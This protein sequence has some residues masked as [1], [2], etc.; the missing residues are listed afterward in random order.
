MLV[1]SCYSIYEVRNLIDYKLI[2]SRLKSAREK[3]QTTQEALAEQAN[4]TVVYLSKIEN[5]KV[6]PTLEVLDAICSV[7]RL[8]IGAV[9]G[10]TSYTLP[11]YQQDRVN[12][13]FQSLSPAVKPIA[14]RMLKDLSEIE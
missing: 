8:D 11:S 10:N 2:G 12:M 1:Q 9:L 5:G 6:H 4:I 3:L 7:L 14:L 13:L